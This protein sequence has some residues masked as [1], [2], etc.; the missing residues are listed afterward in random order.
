MTDIVERLRAEDPECGLRHS[1][2]MEAADLI[3]KQKEYIEVYQDQTNIMLNRISK[4]EKDNERYRL[5]LIEIVQ[6]ERVPV[7]DNRPDFVTKTGT[8]ANDL[9]NGNWPKRMAD[10]EK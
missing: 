6:M 8:F 9:R 3:E 5:G 7:G 10:K 2:A 1:I 4:L